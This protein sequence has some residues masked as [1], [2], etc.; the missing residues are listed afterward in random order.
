MKLKTPASALFA[1]WGL[2]L[3]LPASAVLAKPKVDIT[4]T[5]NDGIGKNVPQDSLSRTGSSMDGALGGVQVFYLNVTVHS[6]NAEAVAKN[7][8]QWCIKGDAL[9][10]SL[11]YH[12]T[13]SGNDLELEVPQP[14]GKIKKM[15]FVVYDRKWRKLSD[16]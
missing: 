11:T 13:L 10:G 9:L 15:T 1:L 6:D 12:G 7:N 4:I 8:G 3:T 2:S 5:V 14:N 16:I